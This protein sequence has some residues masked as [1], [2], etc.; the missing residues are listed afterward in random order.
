MTVDVL[1]DASFDANGVKVACGSSGRGRA[2]TKAV[3]P[4]ADPTKK[5]A[6]KSQSDGDWRRDCGEQLTFGSADDRKMVAD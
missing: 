2:L 5:T 1:D 6:I 4:P 3:A